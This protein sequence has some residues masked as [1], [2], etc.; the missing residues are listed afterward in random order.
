MYQTLASGGFYLPLRS[1]QSVSTQD[2]EL[3]ARYGLEIEQRFAPAVM[4]LL[5]HALARVVTEGTAKSYPFDPGTFFAGKTGTT[6]GLRDSWFAGFS[7][8]FNAVVWMGKDDN[9][10]T[11]FTGSS[12]ALKLWGDIMKKLE[13][14]PGLPQ[15]LSSDVVY[16]RVDIKN[17]NTAEQEGP[18]ST[19]LPFIRGTEPGRVRQASPSGLQTI[20]NKARGIIDSINRIF[21]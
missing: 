5:N 9:S 11:P 1:I 16:V 20:E 2:G 6:D 10:P 14:E 7:N 18:D 3:V 17:R 15:S 4:E 19:I 12:G 21:N 8:S 13:V